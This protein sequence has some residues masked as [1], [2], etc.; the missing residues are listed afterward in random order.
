M[1]IGGRWNQQTGR[2][3]RPF[4]GVM[5][6]LVFNTH[7]PLGKFVSSILQKFLFTVTLKGLSLNPWR[8]KIKNK[9]DLHYNT[10]MFFPW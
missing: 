4:L 2:V 9:Y 10:H 6:G 5:S 7:R 1:Q 3:E 8:M